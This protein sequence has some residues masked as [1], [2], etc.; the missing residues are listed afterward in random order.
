[1]ISNGANVTTWYVNERGHV[2][3]LW[4]NSDEYQLKLNQFFT[5]SLN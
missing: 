1:M 2:D 4:G 5:S 3:A